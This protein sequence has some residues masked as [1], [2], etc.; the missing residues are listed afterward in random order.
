MN[1][2]RPTA[3]WEAAKQRAPELPLFQPSQPGKSQ[4]EDLV[5]FPPEHCHKWREL[6]FVELPPTWPSQKHFHLQTTYNLTDKLNPQ[7]SI[8]SF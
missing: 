6:F 3:K 7:P 5:L 8:I 2:M 4:H 1:T